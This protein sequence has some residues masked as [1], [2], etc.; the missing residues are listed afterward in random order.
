M[1]HI[2]P[3]VA[4]PLYAGIN[5]ALGEGLNY[6]QLG[7]ARPLQFFAGVGLVVLGQCGRRQTSR[8]SPGE[9]A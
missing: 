4:Y 2:P 3:G 5:I 6:L 1:S 9:P 8:H 7:S